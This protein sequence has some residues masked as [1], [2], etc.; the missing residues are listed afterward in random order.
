[1]SVNVI[2]DKLLSTKYM[3]AF[4]PC[5]LFF[6]FGLTEQSLEKGKGLSYI[7]K[8]LNK[9]RLWENQGKI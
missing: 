4:N 1:M 8:N 6:C 5:F 3:T 2:K 7:N 9:F